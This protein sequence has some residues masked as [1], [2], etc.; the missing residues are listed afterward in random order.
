MYSVQTGITQV[1]AVTYTTTQLGI[2]ENTKFLLLDLR[3]PEEYNLYRIKEAISYPAPNIGRDKMIPE[4]FKFKNQPNK[5][6][7]VYMNDE[8]KGT[9]MAQ[10]FFEKGY[11]NTY[12]LSGGIE[13]F[14]EDF[15]ELCEGKVV[16][17]NKKKAQ[18]DEDKKKQEKDEKRKN[19]HAHC[20][21]GK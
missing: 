4:L 21:E 2:T 19:K 18:E 3:D 14:M 8:R 7:V 6:I 17:S 5:L 20:V 10:L 1:S 15:P 16:I 9:A 12:L 11:E 13:Q